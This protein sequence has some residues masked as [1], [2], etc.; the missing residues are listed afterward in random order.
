[1]VEY[2]AL[3]WSQESILLSSVSLLHPLPAPDPG[4]ETREGRA[5]TP[6]SS[7]PWGTRPQAAFSK[8]CKQ[9]RDCLG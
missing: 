8:T 4:Q 6:F 2:T 3:S 1:M 7:T 9:E 5:Q